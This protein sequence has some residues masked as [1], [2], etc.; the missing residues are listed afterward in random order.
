MSKNPPLNSGVSHLSVFVLTLIT[1]LCV[2]LIGTTGFIK[3]Q[4]DR[5]ELALAAPDVSFTPEQEVY[6]KT[7]RSLGYGG[8]L[9]ASYRVITKRDRGA[10]NDMKMHLK[11]AQEIVSRLNEKTPAGIR[12]DLEGIVN[13]YSAIYA[14]AEQSFDNNSVTFTPSDLSPALAALPFFDMRLQAA[15]AQNRMKA[16]DS[17]RFWGLSLTLIAW[18]SLLLAAAM[19]AGIYLVYRNRQAAPLRALAQS[20]RNLARGDMQTPIWGMNRNDAIGDL[21]RAVDLARYHF[22]Q[23]PDLSLMSDQGPVRL[24]FEGETRSIFEAMMRNVADEFEKARRESSGY[25]DNLGSL[26]QSLSTLANNLNSVI[27]QIQIHDSDSHQALQQLVRRI[28]STAQSFTQVQDRAT[29]QMNKLVPYLQE[30]AHSMAEVTSIAGSQIAQSLEKLMKVEEEMRNNAAQSQQVV[31]QFADNTNQLSERL[32]A[33]ANLMQASSKML[34]ETTDTV[35]IRFNEAVESLSRGENHLKDIMGQVEER[36]NHT[37]K[38]E[39]SMAAFASRA[40]T[41]LG[42]ME[43]AVTNMTMRH[44]QLSEHFV[45]ATHRME[46]I[47]ASFDSAQRSMSEAMQYVKRDGELLSGLLQ[48]LRSNNDH[49]LEGITQN[50]QAGYATVQAMAERSQKIMQ[51]IEA[52]LAEQNRVTEMRIGELVTNTRTLNQQ[53]LQATGELVQTVAAMRE[54][55]ERF[56]TTRATFSDSV[57]QLGA[58]LEEKTT[59]T[60]AKT[61]HFA[62]QNFSKLSSL[63]DEMQDIMQRLSILNQLTG[64]LGAVAGQLGQIVPALASG[65]GPSTVSGAN[66]PALESLAE[67]L[68]TQLKGQWNEAM[69]HI[70][71]MH[72]QLAQVIERQKDQ[73]EMRLTIMDK[74]IRAISEQGLDPTQMSFM[75]EIVEMIG[76]IS[77][78]VI[79]LDESIN[80]RNQQR[81]A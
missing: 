57:N 30:R 45:T 43:S 25:A 31:S 63:T 32:F 44:E 18:C 28:D 2:V 73:L 79:M 65:R 76:K 54:E 22:S 50:S 74:K 62:T 47:V 35:Q 12:H 37:A 64:T 66:D 46:G 11:T 75:N 27:S 23:L 8:F 15:I 51:Q 14:K 40:E 34:S 68:G 20:I 24:K 29:T 61:E 80:G 21:A 4:L 70:E 10:L 60:L 3:Y 71:A 33:S 67:E 81:Q 5:S 1:I 13:L 78:H 55:H 77:E 41:N 48:E 26:Q 19:S 59:S 49:L 72:D 52:Q 9:E 16:Q 53:V 39:E 17:Y 38:A 6:N 7:I 69:G 56:T 36:L 42:R 58:K